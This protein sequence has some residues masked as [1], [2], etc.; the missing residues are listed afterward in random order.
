MDALLFTAE[1][2]AE[3]LK[4][5]RWKVYDLLR[6]RDLRSVKIGGSRRVPR[7][8][9]EE[10]VAGCSS[11]GGRLMAGGAQAAGRPTARE[12]LPARQRRPV[13]RPRPTSTP[14]G[15]LERKYGLRP[16][17]DDV[18]DKLAA[19]VEQRSGHPG[20]GQSMT[21]GEYMEH[22]LAIVKVERGSRRPRVRV[23]GPA[24][25]R[26]D[27]RQEASRPAHRCRRPPASSARVRAKC[28]CCTNG[29]QRRPEAEA[30]A[31]RPGSV[32]RAPADDPSGPVR[33]RRAAER[34]E[35]R[36]ARGAGDAQR[37]QAREGPNTAVQGRQGATVDPGQELL[38][39]AKGT[40]WYAL[41]VTRGHA[42]AASRRAAGAALE[43]IDFERATLTV[44]QT[45]QRAA[46][47]LY[48]GP[49]KS[50]ASERDDPAA[51]GHP[52]RARGHRGARTRTAST[53][54][55]W[56][57]HDLVFPST[58]GKPMEPRNLTGLEHRP[59]WPH[60]GSPGPQ[61]GAL[62]DP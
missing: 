53:A 43:D 22:W 24:A 56:E 44:A 20:P 49:A 17:F 55:R 42:R 37:R 2:A 1:E 52:P 57:D 19:A 18:Q 32:L 31:A 8:A 48:V 28:L 25:H 13:G 33:P 62:P 34:A 35:Q 15:P 51:Q 45:S 59:R 26:S 14:R 40:R 38:D 6:N 11:A 4:I 36:R 54:G 9:L 61:S 29:R 21:V 12:H 60:P 30:A 10:Y 5:S 41:Y 50:D 23:G 39:A 58:V 46:G 16:S 27:P 7:A 3:M 47:Q